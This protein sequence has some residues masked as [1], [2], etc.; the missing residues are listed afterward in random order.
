MRMGKVSSGSSNH[1]AEF[2]IIEIDWNKPRIEYSPQ[3]RIF[4]F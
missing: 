1:F 4:G 3:A 2:G